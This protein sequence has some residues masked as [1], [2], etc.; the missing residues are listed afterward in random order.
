[1]HGMM[2]SKRNTDFH[3][4]TSVCLHDFVQIYTIDLAI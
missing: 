3:I 2:N 4:N 1:M